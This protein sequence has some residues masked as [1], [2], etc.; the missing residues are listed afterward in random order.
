MQREAETKGRSVPNPLPASVTPLVS[1][2]IIFLDEEKFLADAVESVLAQTYANWELLLVDDGSSDASASIAKAYCARDHGR[3]RYLTHEGGANRGMSASRNLGLHDARGEFAAF[4]D[5]DDSWAPDKLEQQIAL[6]EVHP[7][8]VMVCGATLY[9]RSWQADPAADEIIFTGD[10]RGDGGWV[11]S[12]EQDHSY[13]AGELLRLLY[14]LGE[15]MTPSSSGII[16]RRDKALAVGGYVEAFRGLF[17]DQVFRAKMYLA[18]PVYVSAKCFD[19]YRQHDQSTSK[20][21]RASGQSRALRVRFLRWLKHYLD[22]LGYRDPEVR[23]KLRKAL[24]KNG[25]PRTYRL[26]ARIARGVRSALAGS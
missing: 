1:C 17:E 9:W 21:A 11:R 6:F 13:Q 2:I 16:V 20:L 4:L 19:R 14:P 12:L 18:G 25:Y 8:A 5:A 26:A 7:E 22:E 23:R 10:V 3:I 15:G 24:L